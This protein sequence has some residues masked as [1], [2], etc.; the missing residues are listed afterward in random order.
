LVFAFAMGCASREPAPTPQAT[1]APPVVE[2]ETPLAAE[3]TPVSKPP[4]ETARVTSSQLN[5]RSGAS[6]NSSI[7]GVLKKGDALEVLSRKKD[8]VEVQSAEGRRGWVAARYLSSEATALASEAP[9]SAAAKPTAPASGPSKSGALSRSDALNLYKR[10]RRALEDSDFKAFLAVVYVPRKPA[11]KATE[12][13]PGEEI[14]HESFAKMK[15]LVLEMSP[16]P[17]VCKLLKFDS[18][19]KAAILVFQS[20]PNSADNITLSAVMMAAEEGQ[21][22]VLP[23]SY[24]DVFSRQNPRADKAAIAEKLKT[25]PMLQLSAVSTKIAKKAE[26]E[27]PPSTVPAAANEAEGELSVN[28]KATALKYAYAYS[29]PSFFDKSRLDTV[30]I[31]S[32]MALDEEAL[33]DWARRQKLEKS[34]TLRCVELTINTGGQ[35]ISRKLRHSAFE[36][37]PSGVSSDEVFEP[38]PAGE[39]FIAGRAYSTKEGEFF[40]VTY[41][42][43]ASFKA[44]IR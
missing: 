21:W 2:S 31:L 24:D 38:S 3:P 42:Y 6:S 20:D 11:G 8:W 43:R 34:G 37:S 32:N 9:G 4:M 28:G 1:K 33:T 10:F 12:T 30:V 40:G 41:R 13:T 27:A 36:A 23:G 15:D 7:L 35:V 22:R 29:K 19:V 25:N 5:L 16:D 44:Q 17:A 26:V 14:T 39:G 18:D